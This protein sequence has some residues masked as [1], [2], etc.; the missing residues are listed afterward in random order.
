MGLLVN[1]SPMVE[2]HVK[3][4]GI[5][6]DKPIIITERDV[7]EVVCGEAKKYAGE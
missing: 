6:E 4:K 2:H 5:S 3:T 1:L 7:E